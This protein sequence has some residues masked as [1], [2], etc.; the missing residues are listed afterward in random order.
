MKKIIFVLI[1]VAI[2]SGMSLVFAESNSSSFEEE[3]VITEDVSSSEFP[4]GNKPKVAQKVE[5]GV[6]FKE[7]TGNELSDNNDKKSRKIIK[8]FSKEDSPFEKNNKSISVFAYAYPGLSW[9][10]WLGSFGYQIGFSGL[11]LQNEYNEYKEGGQTETYEYIDSFY[12]FTAEAQFEFFTA[13]FSKNWYGRLYGVVLGG[14]YYETDYDVDEIF[15]GIVGL[16]IGFETICYEHFS[17]PLHF[18]YY[19]EFP[20]NFKMDFMVGGGIRFRF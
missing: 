15:N 8:G 14:F 16:G 1:I 5:D 13:R 6:V 12:M 18:G 7:R 19:A 4:N 10:Q 20:N 11:Y 9:Q 2:F 17:I 3:N